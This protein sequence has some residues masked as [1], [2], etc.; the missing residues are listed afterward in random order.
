MRATAALALA[1]LALSPP[2]RAAD[3]PAP[4]PTLDDRLGKLEEDL[5]ETQAQVKQLLPLTG[6]LSGY[7]DFGFFRVSGDGSGVRPDLGNKIFPEY[8]YAGAWSFM[9]DPLATMINARGEPADTG[10]SRAVTFN[11]VHAGD[12][13]SFIV[14]ALTVSL[15]AGVGD[16]LIVQGIFDLVP[17]SRDVSDPSGHFLGDF[18]DVKLA[19]VEW[20]PKLDAF[21]LSIF[22]GK[23]DSVLGIEYRVEEAPDRIGVTPS[24]ICRYT[25]GR[26]LGVKARARFADD[27]F[28]LNLAVTNGTSFLEMFPFYNETDVNDGKTVS[29]RVST[30]LPVGNGLELGA[31]G[32]V[33]P[34]DN[35]SQDSIWQWHV[36]ADLHLD[37]HDV[38]LSA[39]YVKGKA[40]GATDTGM[41]ANPCDLA[42]CLDYQGAYGLVG[43]RAT[44]WLIP[45][46]RVD[47]RDALH[48]SGA[49]F[50]YVSQL[51]RATAGVRLELGSAVIV[52]AE[53][54]LNRELGKIP[55]FD[56]DIF[57]S[58]LVVKY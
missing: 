27:R 51:M 37:F 6:R 58:S 31:S 49:S 40:E 19:Y 46:A 13:A 20:R 12:H 42:P 38:D 47:W 36:G 57:T 56:D 9:G 7:L 21:A 44:N 3:P 23:I 18:L 39:E 50:V 5:A 1:V 43:Y 32:A 15:F 11:P 48:R 4:A 35:Q 55:Q 8:A 54:T 22:A 10:A 14:N 52:K 2:A 41:N 26:P 28:V 29:A 34:Q 53:Y 33:G 25:C 30:R 45:Y 24:L 17:R 16:D